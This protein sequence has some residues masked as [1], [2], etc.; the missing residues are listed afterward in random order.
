MSGEQLYQ[1]VRTI[2][3]EYLAKHV[4]FSNV[5]ISLQSNIPPLFSNSFFMV[6]P[7]TEHHHLHWIHQD[8]GKN[9]SH[10]NSEDTHV[11]QEQ[12]GLFG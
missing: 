10:V 4:F 3:W 5:F 8:P 7:M 1:P 12:L 11:L 6:F 2:F 9:T